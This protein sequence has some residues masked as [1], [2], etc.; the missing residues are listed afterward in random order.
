MHNKKQSIVMSRKKLAE[1]G[2]QD[3]LLAIDILDS[4]SSTR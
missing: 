3:N 4:D 2:G 1:N